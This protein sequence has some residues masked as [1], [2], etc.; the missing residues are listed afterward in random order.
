MQLALTADVCSFQQECGPAQ[1]QLQDTILQLEALELGHS[2]DRHS[3]LRLAQ[4]KM[5]ALE[6][7]VRY[8][9]TVAIKYSLGPARRRCRGREGSAGQGC[10]MREETDMGVV[11]AEALSEGWGRRWGTV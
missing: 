4:Q 6:G 3:I 2:E 7:T 11:R 1:A 10:G 5:P 9:Q 8:L